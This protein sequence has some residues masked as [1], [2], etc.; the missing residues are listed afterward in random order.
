MTTAQAL[1]LKIETRASFG[2]GPVAAGAADIRNGL[3]AHYDGSD[4]GLANKPHSA[5]RA[6]WVSTRKF[7]MGP[8]RRW[9]DIGYSYGVCPH[10]IVMEGRGLNRV[11]AA[12]PGGN[13]TWYS[14]T[15]MSGPDDLVT[16]AQKEAFR[17][18]RAWLMGKGVAGAVK[19]HRDFVSTSCPGED[20]YRMVRSGELRK[21]PGSDTPQEEESLKL[22]CSLGMSEPVEVQPGQRVDLLLDKEY[23]DPDGVHGDGAHGVAPEEDGAYLVSAEVHLDGTT[24]SGP[25]KIALAMFAETDGLPYERDPFSQ[26][27][28]GDVS[29]QGV[30]GMSR[31]EALY[32]NKRYRLAFKNGAATPVTVEKAY[33]KLAR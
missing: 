2:W 29:G 6:Y 8:E 28:A 5:C 15:F 7:H 33:L 23:R 1:K 17:L 27:I 30:Y 3:V 16:L 10:G 9:N 14:C 24:E 26:S 22:V 31:A 12:Q 18:L 21:P 25:Y 4:Q 11:Q 13:S 19:G 32:K 20:I